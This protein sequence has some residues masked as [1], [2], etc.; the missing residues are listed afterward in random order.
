M[1]RGAATACLVSVLTTGF[2]AQAPQAP[3]ASDLPAGPGRETLTARCVTCHQSDVI[4]QQRLSRAGWGREVDKMVRWGA[5]VDAAERE[6]LL[7][8]LAGHF[9]PTPVASHIV[10]T[11]S[12]ESTYKRACFVCHEDDVIEAQRLSREG[13]GREVDKMMRWGA[14]VSATDRDA[15]VDYLAAR[16]PRR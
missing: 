7:D 16:Y 10:A 12:S 15:L 4:V 2:A 1:G 5:V 13:W 8:Y 3:P 9:A 14:N 11:A 6:P